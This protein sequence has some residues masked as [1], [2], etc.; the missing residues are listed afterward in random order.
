MNVFIIC[1]VRNITDKEKDAL[2]RFVEELENQGNKVH[3]PPR[4]TNQNDPTGLRICKDN[5]DAIE[6]A[7]YV[8]VWWNEESQGSLFDIGM[9]FALKKRVCLINSHLVIKTV[10]KSFNNVLLALHHFDAN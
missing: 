8:Y 3:W 6:K 9:A 1:P 2:M 7:D 4:D 5:R 10:N